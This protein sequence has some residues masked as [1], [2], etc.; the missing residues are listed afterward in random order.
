M[1]D[2]YV[3]KIEP[4]RTKKI[5]YYKTEKF[6]THNQFLDI[7]LIAG[8]PGL[9]ILLALFIVPFL[10]QKTYSE[11]LTVLVLFFLFM[12]VENIFQRQIGCFLF[13]IFLGLYAPKE[14]QL[15]WSK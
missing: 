15:S 14:V 2:C 8:L 3:S 11:M 13:G 7:W 6:N 4:G 12:L 10:K 9:S 5:N 1:T